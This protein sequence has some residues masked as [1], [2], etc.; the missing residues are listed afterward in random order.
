[1]TEKRKIKVKILQSCAGMWGAAVEGDI[2][3]LPG[4]VA[5]SLMRGGLA[6]EPNAPP[7]KKNPSKKSKTE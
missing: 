2:V 6:I 7:V 1:M 5:E 4:D 3:E